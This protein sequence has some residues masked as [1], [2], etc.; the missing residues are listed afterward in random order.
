MLMRYQNVHSVLELLVIDPVYTAWIESQPREKREKAAECKRTIRSEDLDE[1]I[2]TAI[3]IME[4]VYRL[5]RLT[6]GKL[7]ANLG[8]VYA[9]LL[10]IDM[11]LR[12]GHIP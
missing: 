3:A 4:P 11:H 9:Y 5:L 6:D 1:T 10:Q 7:G 2:K 8:K 12:E